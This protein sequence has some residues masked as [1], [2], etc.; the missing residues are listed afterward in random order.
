[1]Q[2]NEEH[3]VTCLGHVCWCCW[4]LSDLSGSWLLMLLNIRWPVWVM[5]VDAVA[6]CKD[7]CVCNGSCSFFSF[8]VVFFI[9]FWQSVWRITDVGVF[10]TR[11]AGSKQV[12]SAGKWP[13]QPSHKHLL[14]LGAA[15]SPSQNSAVHTPFLSG[16]QDSAVC[17]PGLWW[18]HWHVL[19]PETLLSVTFAMVRTLACFVSWNTT[20]CDPSNGENTGMFCVLNHYHLWPLLGWEHWHVLCPEPLPSVTLARVRTLACL[21]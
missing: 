15:C 10:E 4:T 2:G 11:Q 18:E 19:S 21:C 16:P 13:G 9:F 12:G 1:M 8:Q 14:W 5:A 6:P 7:M 20:I 3:Q 17:P